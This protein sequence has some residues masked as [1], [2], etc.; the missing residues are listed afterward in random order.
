MNILYVDFDKYPLDMIYNMA[1]KFETIFTPDDPLF[2][3]PNDCRLVENA[4]Y[5]ELMNIKRIVDTALEEK[6]KNGISS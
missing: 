6:E 4:S 2:V 3:F 5:E 1:Q